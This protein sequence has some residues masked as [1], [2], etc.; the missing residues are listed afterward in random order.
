M[1]ASLAGSINNLVQSKTLKWIFVGGKGGVGKTTTS[2]SLA[3]ALAATRKSVLL[4]SIDPAHNLSD[5]FGQKFSN[6]P[7]LVNSFTNLHAMEVE[8]PQT[9]SSANSN[10]NSTVANPTATTPGV[11]ATPDSNAA[12]SEFASSMMDDF[13]STLPGIDEAMAFGTLMKSVREMDHDV[14]IFDTAPTG[15]TMRL[16]GFPSLL[17]KA[18]SVF[19]SL[20]SRFGPMASTVASTL[21]TQGIDINTMIERIEGMRDVTR[22]VSE[23]FADSAKCTF[24]CVCIPEFLSVFE[25][26]RLVQEV[27]K[28]DISVTNIV[29]NQV[30][31]DMDI[32]DRERGEQ[33]YRARMAMQTKYL[34]Q[35]VELYGEDFHITSMPLLTGEVRGRDALDRFSRLLLEEKKEFIEGMEGMN[36]LGEYEGSLKNVI[37]DDNIHWVFVGGKGG[38]GKTTSSS[39]IGVSFE[40]KGFKT[41]LV[42]TDPAHNL[43]DAFG[44]KISSGTEPTKINGYSSLFAM[45]VNATEAAE[46]FVMRIST[47]AQTATNSGGGGDDGDGDGDEA[48]AMNMISKLLPPD[49][50]RQLVS[51]IPG[52]D[53]AV[54]FMQIVKLAKSMSFDRIVFDTA[55]TGHTLR[56]L[57]FPRVAD[58]ALTRVDD[59]RQ[60]LGPML[61]MMS[62]GDANAQ[63]GLQRIEEELD[64]WKKGLVEVTNI[65]ND[66]ERSTFVCVAI[67]E[68]LSVYET[69]RLVQQL[70]ELNVN[71]RNILVNQLMSPKEKDV[72]SVLQTR[73]RMQRKYLEQ[74]DELY[75]P[76]DFHITYMPLLPS[77]I[78]GIEALKQYGDLATSGGADISKSSPKEST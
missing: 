54:S 52:I 1:A 8:P 5:A 75:P 74:V 63:R 36:E 49:T 77:E 33:L 37:D 42:S 28:F 31:R 64:K 35:V 71:V 60:R 23:V 57:G 11:G 4:V 62:G 69:E 34:E 10:N 43:S 39:S 67:A 68:F 21:G 9:N 15:H 73:S 12:V 65:L 48:G 19:Q 14:V 27:A 70:C 22:E 50:L 44:Q 72:F 13:G 17:E 58:K 59:L 45:E 26:E 16:L 66:Q 41:L 47:E 78:R 2:C 18:L 20:V 56:L 6:Q 24:V 40:R 25:T 51:S 30:L 38:V 7:T 53:E 32:N 3:V 55:P 46:E 29:V 61:N 76:E